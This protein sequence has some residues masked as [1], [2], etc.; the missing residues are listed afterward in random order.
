M[1][2]AVGNLLLTTVLPG[3]LL[4]MLGAASGCVVEAR[5]HVAAPVAVV[6]VEADE[7]P[8]PP[9]QVVVETRPG[10][11]FIE[12]H[13]VRHGGRWEWSDGH[14]ERQRTNYVWVQ[15]HWERRG[16]RSVWV[17]GEWRASN[18]VVRD[19]R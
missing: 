2:T 3:V 13:W 7:E 10:F 14:W 5:G 15:G 9:R 16:R 4:G 12:G 1:K 17:E 19:H 11:I 8:P 6:E 18:T